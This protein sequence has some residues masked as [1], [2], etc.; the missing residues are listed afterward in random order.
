M[1]IREIHSSEVDAYK[2]FFVNMLVHNSD[3]FRISPND[4]I[5]GPFPTF[6]TADSFTLG[7]YFDNKLA[8]VVSFHRERNREKLHHKG[9]LFRMCVS[10]LYRRTGVGRALI[11]TLLDRVKELKE[12]EQISLTVVSSNQSA[13][14]LYGEF[15][16]VVCGTEI[17]AIK[18]YGSYYD[19]DQMILLLNTS[20][21]KG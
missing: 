18:W 1:E 5:S 11:A 8:A 10:S 7:A 17:N 9:L 3:Y 15:G 12:I 13:K 16:F 2:A 14:A 21:F 6:D 20:G 4:E 19:E